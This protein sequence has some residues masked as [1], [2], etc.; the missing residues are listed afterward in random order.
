MK[1]GPKDK[2]YKLLNGR[3][4]NKTEFITY[5]ENKV[6]KTIRSYKLLNL[7]DK[8]VVAVSGG[9]DSI[10]VLYLVHKYLKRK[11]LQKNIKALAIDEGIA[12]YRE[13]T[14]DFLRDLCEHPGSRGLCTKTF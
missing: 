2:V 14:L 12:D 9:K 6:F 13:K 7:D 4:L 5:F 11:N 1:I 10:T 8:L 3:I